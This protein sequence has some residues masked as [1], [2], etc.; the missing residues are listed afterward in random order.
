MGKRGVLLPI[1]LQAYCLVNQAYGAGKLQY[2][3]I[4]NNARNATQP[5]VILPQIFQLNG[6][7]HSKETGGDIGYEPLRPV[8]SIDNVFIPIPDV[9]EQSP[10]RRLG[11]TFDAALYNDNTVIRS[12]LA[13]IQNPETEAPISASEKRYMEAQD[14]RARLLKRSGCQHVPTG[15]TW[16][17]PGGK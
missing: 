10:A 4:S 2:R 6:T 1:L 5:A 8:S 14:A 12:G 17:C 7:Y 16:D 11:D 13:T 15:I 3:Q 9:P